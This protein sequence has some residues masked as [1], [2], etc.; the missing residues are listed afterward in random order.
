MVAPL[1]QI[2]NRGAPVI[3]VLIDSASFSGTVGTVSVANS[4]VSSGFQVY[5]IRHGEE[6]ARALDSRVLIPQARY[7]GEVV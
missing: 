4:L 2:K 5:V 7:I 6:L 1:R 3:V